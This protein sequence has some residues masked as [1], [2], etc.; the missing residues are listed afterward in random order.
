MSFRDG[1]HPLG[2]TV[3]THLSDDTK[4]LGLRG[5]RAREGSLA[6]PCYSTRS[7]IIWAIR[8]NRFHSAGVSVVDK[9]T[10]WSPWKAHLE[11]LMQTPGILEQGH[12]IC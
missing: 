10:V 1:V 8:Y 6:D 4:L 7:P 3:V 11:K 2:N 12:V 9:D 5:F